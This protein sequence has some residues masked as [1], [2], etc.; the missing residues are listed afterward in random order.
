MSR[1]K[2]TFLFSLTREI[3]AKTIRNSLQITLSPPLWW[4][5]CQSSRFV[6]LLF[7]LLCCFVLF[8]YVTI[9]Y[10]H[11]FKILLQLYKEMYTIVKKSIQYCI[12]CSN[13]NK[14]IIVILTHLN[15]VYQNRLLTLPKKTAVKARKD[16]WIK[17]N[18]SG[19]TDN[20]NYSIFVLGDY[21][22][23]FVQSRC[24]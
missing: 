16:A 4:T 19:K 14:L 23:I 11:Y 17:Y 12:N 9:Y 15:L 10:F 1:K 3:Y 2:S 8:Y 18:L 22:T 5:C 13:H 6:P 24:C 20:F 21:L 7:L